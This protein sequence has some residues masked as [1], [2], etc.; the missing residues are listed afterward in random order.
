MVEQ[1]NLE[2]HGLFGQR[3]FVSFSKTVVGKF[4]LSYLLVLPSEAMI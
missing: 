2:H 4:I 1:N 3:R